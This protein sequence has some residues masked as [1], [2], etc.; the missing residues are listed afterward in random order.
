MRR[1]RPESRKSRVMLGEIKASEN[2]AQSGNR[3][4]ERIEEGAN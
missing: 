2:D 4:A 3:K 1:T